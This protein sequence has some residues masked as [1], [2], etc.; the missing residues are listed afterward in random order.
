MLLNRLLLW[1]S[2]GVIVS[3]GFNEWEIAAA[4]LAWFLW[5]VLLGKRIQEDWFKLLLKIHNGASSED[6]AKQTRERG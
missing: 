3:L 2:L 6:I 1:V 5:G 4:S